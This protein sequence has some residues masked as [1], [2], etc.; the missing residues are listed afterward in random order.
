[1]GRGIL[2]APGAW[3]PF[4]LALRVLPVSWPSPTHLLPG[5]T[6]K[7]QGA[8][9]DNAPRCVHPHSLPATCPPQPTGARRPSWSQ[10]C[11]DKQTSAG[12]ESAVPAGDPPAAGDTKTRQRNVSTKVIGAPNDLERISK[13][14]PGCSPSSGHSPEKSSAPGTL[15]TP[16]PRL[17]CQ[18]QTPPP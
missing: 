17:L 7:C 8:L 11:P 12:T 5:S 3:T 2:T 14:S 9:T 1:M 6:H 10:A 15:G 13:G 16:N 4:V 18:T